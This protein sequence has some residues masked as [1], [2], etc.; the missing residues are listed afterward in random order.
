[1][2]FL[3][4]IYWVNKIKQVNYIIILLQGSMVRTHAHHY[5]SSTFIIAKEKMLLLLL[6]PGNKSMKQ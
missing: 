6:L 4:S 5:D 2:F 3:V 1:M